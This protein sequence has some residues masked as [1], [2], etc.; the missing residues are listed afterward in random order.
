MRRAVPL[1]RTDFEFQATGNQC[2]TYG[3]DLWLPYH[4]CGNR[5][6]DPYTFRSNMAPMMGFVWD[7]RRKDLDYNLIRK[8]IGQWRDVAHCY[9]GDMYP[10]TPYSTAEDVWMA[11]QFDRPEGGEGMVQ[12]FRRPESPY[13]SA[14]FPLRALDP[15]AKYSVANCDAPNPMEFSGRDLVEKGLVITLH[16]QPGA[17][18]FTY[19]RIP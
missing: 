15:D 9:F 5:D 12:A 10:L 1:L 2:H 18:V 7:T 3:F 8:L 14:A 4:E 13:V 19:K 11:W 16:D 17:A 6:Y